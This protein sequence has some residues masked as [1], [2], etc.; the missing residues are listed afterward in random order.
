MI[1]TGKQLVALAL[2][3]LATAANAVPTQAPAVE[4]QSSNA[5]AAQT[6]PVVAAA[7]AVP[8]LPVAAPSLQQAALADPSVQLAMLVADS[9]V[10]WQQPQAEPAQ[11]QPAATS[12]EIDA[13][14]ECM[15][16]VVHHEAGNQ[17]RKGQL[18]VAQLIMNRV[19]SGRFAG[20]ICGVANQR[21]QFFRTDSYNPRRDTD[22]WQNAV[23]VSREARDG[24]SD[25]VAPGALFFH[26]A[27]AS[28][29]SFFQSRQRV[30]TLGGN[31]FY[32]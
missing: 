3:P 6:V 4:I 11:A 29:G 30:T 26:A 10:T 25:E 21:G 27:Y 32:R 22:S 15:A 31:V 16:K 20:T 23:E 1:S 18:A 14:L 13:E 7:P 2:L 24:R 19:E 28:G 9:S 5:L 17:S 8:V 12:A